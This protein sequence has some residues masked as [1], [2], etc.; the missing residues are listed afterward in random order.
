MLRVAIRA[1]PGRGCGLRA[2]VGTRPVPPS[3]W[4]PH[5]LQGAL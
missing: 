4:P 2:A 3:P 1:A 5:D